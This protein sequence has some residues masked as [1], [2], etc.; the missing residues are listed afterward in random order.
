[1]QAQADRA[2]AD[3]RRMVEQVNQDA[4]LAREAGEVIVRIEQGA[5][6]VVGVASDITSA[7]REQAVASDTIARQLET[8]AR[9]SDESTAALAQTSG[10]ARDL[11]A[12]AAH[13][14]DAAARFQV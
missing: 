6:R 13:M 8:I 10:S 4:E 7:L 3:M 9:S 5:Q 2:V 1:M 12:M 14:H 11:E